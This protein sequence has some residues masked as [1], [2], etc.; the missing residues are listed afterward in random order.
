MDQIIITD[1]E[2][3]FH[4]GVPDSERARPQRLLISLELD[5]D[6]TAAAKGDEI[7]KTINYYDVCHQI[8]DFGEGRSWK[9]I[10]TLASDVANLV[11]TRFRPTSVTVTVKKFILP[12][13]KHVSVRLTRTL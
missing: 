8:A 7:S 1:L 9:L 2:V 3:S 4:V 5:T 11:L 12:Q 13:T 6:F 10:E